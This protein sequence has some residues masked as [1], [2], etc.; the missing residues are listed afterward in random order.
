MNAWGG[1]DWGYWNSGVCSFEWKLLVVKWSGACTRVI[2]IVSCSL[3]SCSHL[4][5][6]KWTKWVN[7]CA[8]W[9]RRVCGERQ[10]DGK[11]REGGGTSCLFLIMFI[12]PYYED[13]DIHQDCSVVISDL[14]F[15]CVPYVIVVLA[16][17]LASFPCNA[18][19]D[20]RV[21][22]QVFLVYDCRYTQYMQICPKYLEAFRAF[23]KIL[24][25]KMSVD[26]MAV[27]LLIK[28]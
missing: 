17:F 20:V 26:N 19:S 7:I 3:L 4:P 23:F 10:G 24:R 14:F 16:G 22:Y 15:Y 18:G 27:S 21:T 2:V 12:I 28:V 25:E 11:R 6:L 13:A 8:I 5:L 9:S 1:F